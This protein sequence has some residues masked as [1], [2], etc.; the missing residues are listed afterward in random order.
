MSIT[1]RSF[2]ARILGSGAAVAS[3]AT[4]GA[5]VA[6]ARGNK[7]L[8]PKAVGLLYDSTLCTGCKACVVGCKIA[9][10]KPLSTP[11]ET[12]YLDDTKELNPDA[13]NVIQMYVNGTPSAKDREE[14][15][16]AFFKHSCMHCVDPSCV[17]ACPVQAL[18]KDAENGVVTW[19]R[20]ACIGCRYCVMACAFR[21]PKFRYTSAFDPDINK[22]QLCNHLWAEGKYSA[23]AYVCP[24]GATLYGPVEMLHKEA[25]R[26][27]SL[28]PGEKFRT[29]RGR[30][31]AKKPQRTRAYTVPNYKQ[32]IY[33]E[34][35]GGG[36]QM[37]M[38]SAVDFHKLG[39]PKVQRR[40]WASISETV[41]HTLY[42]YLVFPAIALAGLMAITYR[43][44]RV[45]EDEEGEET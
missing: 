44:A 38:L 36:T 39:L 45:T 19:S 32:H 42:S 9:N 31:D 10:G 18:Q 6:E 14:N 3:A 4:A 11:M 22:C 13:L 29:V 7:T 33:G 40:S 8:P 35:E 21:I 24:T 26:R 20:D 30:I 43:T 17:S 28:K 12:A 23:C 37:L 25:K 27:L 15:G 5:P 1:R 41:Q 16:F 34:T 2:L